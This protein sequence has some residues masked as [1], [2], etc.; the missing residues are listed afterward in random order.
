M[1]QRRNLRDLR[2]YKVGTQVRY[3][4]PWQ[5]VSRP[6]LHGGW[7]TLGYDRRGVVRQADSGDGL[8]QVEFP[9]YSPPLL[10]WVRAMQLE[11]FA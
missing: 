5:R 6:G 11:V 1:T 9:N 3:V 8:I 4:G 10:T 7:A 2:R